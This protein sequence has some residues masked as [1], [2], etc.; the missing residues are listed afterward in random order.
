MS[1]LITEITIAYEKMRRYESDLDV[2]RSQVRTSKKR[3]AVARKELDGL[4]DELKNGQGRLPFGDRE[5]E[6]GDEATPVAPVVTRKAK[7]AGRDGDR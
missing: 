6:P 1:T 2:A 7:A 3:I 4:L 5:P